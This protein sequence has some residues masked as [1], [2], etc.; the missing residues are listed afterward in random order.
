MR[1]LSSCKLYFAQANTPRRVDELPND[2][3]FDDHP[4][5]QPIC[6]GFE[7]VRELSSSGMTREHDKAAR[8]GKPNC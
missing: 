6:Q 5:S 2:E 4:W 7:I 3:V 1:V 8:P